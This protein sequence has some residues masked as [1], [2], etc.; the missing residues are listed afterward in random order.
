MILLDVLKTFAAM[1]NREGVLKSFDRIKSKHPDYETLRTEIENLPTPVILPEINDFIFGLDADKINDHIRNIKDVFMM[2]E[3][4]LFQ[5]SGLFDSR[6]RDVEFVL[7]IFIGKPNDGKNL[8]SIEHTLLMDD[9]LKYAQRMIE[10]VETT[11][12]DRCGATRYMDNAVTILP[13][14][15]LVLLNCHGWEISFRKKANDL[16]FY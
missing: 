4:G 6:V 3:Y 11:D 10:H 13:I 14:Q 8:D 2:V 12:R 7:T 1:P 9:L 5:G 16:F 15:P